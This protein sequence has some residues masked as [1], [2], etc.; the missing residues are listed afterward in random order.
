M[1]KAILLDLDNTLLQNPDRDFATA[2]LG[3]LK[4]HFAEQLDDAGASTQFHQ[5]LR[6]LSDTARNGQQTNLDRIV[7]AMGISDLDQT[8]RITASINNFYTGPYHHLQSCIQPVAG[9]ADLIHQL[10]DAGYT[11]VI[12]T[13]PFYPT[14]AIQERMVWGGL[15]TD[16]DLYALI[17]GADV[18]HFCKPDPAYYAEILGRV[19]VEPDEAIMIGD[20]QRND[21]RPAQTLGIRTYHLSGQQ[22]LHGF[23]DHITQQLDLKP[24]HLSPAMI[25]PQLRG[26]IGALYGFLSAVKNDYWQQRPDPN[27]WSI[28]QILCHLVDAERTS[29]RP[30]LQRIASEDNPFIAAPPEP[31]ADIPVCNDDGYQI[32]Q[33]LT[34]ERQQTITFVNSLAT[35]DWGRRARH[36]I[37]GLTTLLEM[38]HFTAQHDR[39]HLNQL[40]QTIGRCR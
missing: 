6:S 21:I 39:L 40:C 9:A 17:T 32:A 27:E 38:A 30:R 22:T 33:Q 31:G 4:A 7:E 14:T 12:A 36:S 29:E 35:A 37:F 11:L 28:L 13:N 19:G 25:A 34:Q 15:P 20:S 23:P 5:A 1:I 24:P 18:M 8:E 3:Q 10:R 16:D 26:N 2:F